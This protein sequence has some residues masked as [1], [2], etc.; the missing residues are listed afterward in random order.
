MIESAIKYVEEIF[1]DDCS[2]HDYHHTM[3]VYR[4]AMKIAEYENADKLIV[5][6][7]ALLHD[8]DDVKVSP[9]THTTK[10]NAVDFM[11]R[12]GV[13]DAVV[14][15]VCRIIAEVSFAGTDSVVPST[16]EGKCVQDADRLDAMG[17]IGIARAFAYGGSK[18]RKLYD[19]E[20]K[21]LVNMSKEE[22]QQ[23][24]DSTSVNHFYEK[25]LLLK[26]MMNTETAKRI[27]EHRQVVM[28][29]YLEEF[30]AEWEGER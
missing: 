7:A 30:I 24:Q 21:P 10:K 6:L 15:S 16:I 19:P 17:A 5:Q 27:A 8:V 29:N 1:A 26:D 12:N 3:R 25:L 4:L 13:N 11:R 20:I 18:G 23:N 9:E 2:G 14:N 28:E 22:Y